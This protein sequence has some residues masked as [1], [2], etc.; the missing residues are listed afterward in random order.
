MISEILLPADQ[1]ATYKGR[2]LLHAPR[3]DP[4]VRLSRIRLPPWVF[5]GKA[6]AWPRMKD[7]G[8]GKEVVSQLLDPCP[9]RA[10]LLTAPSKRA[11]PESGDMDPEGRKCR[12][13]GRHCMV[14]IEA[15][16]DLP[17]PHPLP[18]DG[19][20][21]SPTQFVPHF[22]ELGHCAITPGFPLEQ[23]VSSA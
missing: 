1:A 10:V 23:E 12:E 4:Y 2:P 19:Q 8:F 14:T 21:H 18:G 11:P 6:L 7:A 20:M 22:L 9:R 5:D 16:D 3:T 13:V 15:G 17:Q